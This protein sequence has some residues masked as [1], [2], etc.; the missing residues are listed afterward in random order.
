MELE[1]FD[2]RLSAL[3]VPGRPGTQVT[4]PDTEVLVLFFESQHELVVGG[5]KEDRRI[6]GKLNACT[7]PVVLERVKHM[8][9]IQNIQ[10]MTDTLCMI[11]K[12]RF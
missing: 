9:N 6:N 7:I 1:P 3:E 5:R 4:R 8:G 2:C 10:N 11:R 12:A